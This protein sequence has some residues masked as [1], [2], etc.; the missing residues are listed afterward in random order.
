MTNLYLYR[1]THIENIPHILRYGIT[2]QDSA[3]SN[4]NY[5]SI[6]DGSLIAKR[7]HIILSET[8]RLGEFI[9]FYF[10]TRMPMLFVIKQG[11]NSI[12]YN[13][14]TTPS[15]KIIYC[16]TSIE[17]ILNHKLDF[18]FSN[19]HAVNDLTEFFDS[20]RVD[21]IEQII[22]LGAV[23]A[24][25]WIEKQDLDLKRRKEAE[26]LIR[27]DIPT[28]AIVG[29]A[30]YNSAAKDNLISLGVKESLIGVRPE[31]YF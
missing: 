9:P 18:I 30:V 12:K 2:H 15:E 27:D 6:G 1:M 14:K 5:V 29:Y 24:K 8:K 10:G 16:V 7:E 19:G 22:D 11:A 20:A 28:S 4:K 25:Y 23:Q 31:Y 17:Q 26:F 13:L 21:E 3:N